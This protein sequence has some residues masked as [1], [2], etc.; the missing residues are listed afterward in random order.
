MERFKSEYR[1]QGYEV[2]EIQQCDLDQSLA[3]HW[4]EK[5]IFWL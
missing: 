2:T 3:E 1:L 4:Q 5:P